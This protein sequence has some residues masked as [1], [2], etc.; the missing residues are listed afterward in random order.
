MAAF[1]AGRF[2]GDTVLVADPERVA[3]PV[4]FC[5]SVGAPCVVML[6]DAAVGVV[7][8]CLVMCVVMS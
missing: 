8:G 2:A 1:C 7:D 5:C 4:S 3:D 6:V